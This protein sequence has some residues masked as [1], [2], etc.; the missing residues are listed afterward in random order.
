M[1]DVIIVGA[2]VAGTFVARELAAYKLDV[3]LLEKE[4]DV[5]NKTS[6]AN[7]AIIHA[8]Y[9]AKAGKLKGKFN[10]PGNKMY[11]KVCEELD[12]MFDMCG[13]FVIG[14][15]EE[16]KKTIEY[17]YENGLKNGV[18]GMKI[19]TGDE[20]RAKEPHLSEE[21]IVALE[22]KTAGVVAPF[23]LTVA[24]AENAVD[25]GV[26]LSLETEV[27]DI[28]TFDEH[29]EII[30]NKGNF[31]C[32]YV[33][34]CAGVYADKINDM[35]AE[36]YFEIKA[37]KGHYFV[38]D[39]SEREIMKTVI[40]Q[41]PSAKGKG[42][43]VAPTVHGNIL[44]GP[45]SEFVDEK[46]DNSTDSA[47]LAYTR[48]TAL[49]TTKDLDF[50]KVIRVFAGLRASSSGGDF[51][52]EHVKGTRGL[53]NVAGYES[54]GLSAIPAV[55]LEVVEILRELRGGLEKNESYNPRRRKVVRFHELSEEEKREKIKEDIRY[56]RV[57]CRCET[58]TEAEIVDCIHRN[59]GAK[60]IKGVKK[61]VRPG[62]GRC[63]GGFCAPRVQEILAREL[64]VDMVDVPYDSTK[65][66]IL[67]ED[68]N[69]D[70][71]EGGELDA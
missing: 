57:I 17:L 36:H 30:T 21:V 48:A 5:G 4:N 14:F 65:A 52:I 66:Y 69:A 41:C 62:A 70:I 39:L 63:Q 32:K 67:T 51:I 11:P 13:S 53:I 61:R 46:F 29:Y 54:P 8:G 22:A 16:D 58:V 56:A 42:V 27:L 71:D 33:I 44:V 34:N 59:V 20:A 37:R 55:A 31:E 40:F 23:E 26:E 7:S 15:D 3:L 1:Y 12:V 28:K 38:M 19:L 35:L 25:N 49:K 2:G 50:S 18:E 68:M 43:L 60:T 6:A 47:R 45:D 10:A 24:L 9:D 64:G